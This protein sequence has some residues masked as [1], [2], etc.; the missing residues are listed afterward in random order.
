MSARSRTPRSL[1]LGRSRRIQDHARVHA[2]SRDTV[3]GDAD[4]ERL[5]EVRQRI[6]TGAAPWTHIVL[7]SLDLGI[8]VVEAMSFVALALEHNLVVRFLD[9]NEVL[10]GRGEGR[11]IGACAR[12]LRSAAGRRG[13][14]PRKELDLDI[15]AQLR[16][17]HGMREAA[18]QL[19][20]SPSTLRARLAEAGGT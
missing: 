7:E 11:A 8:P 10:E 19:G 1:F 9:V 2:E 16:A 3:I 14:R 5:R 4:A 13:G 12:A 20:V 18:K 15:A 6:A 17:E